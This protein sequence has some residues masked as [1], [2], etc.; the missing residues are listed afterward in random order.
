MVHGMPFFDVVKDETKEGVEPNKKAIRPYYVPTQGNVWSPLL[1]Y[2]VNAKCF[3][4]SKLK[5][6]KCCMPKLSRAMDVKDAMQVLK[7]WDKIILGKI[8]I[9]EAE[10]P[11][12]T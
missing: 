2:P 3:C 9:S 7:D 11:K 1:R 5:A 10:K 6:K 12:E 4:G 8:L